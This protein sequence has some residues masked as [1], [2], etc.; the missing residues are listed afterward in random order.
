MNPS[1]TA[2]GSGDPDPTIEVEEPKAPA[3]DPD[4][5]SIVALFFLTNTIL[6][7]PCKR[8]YI[9]VTIRDLQ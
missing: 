4:Q 1:S 2:A 6:G 5:I 9:R 3:E 8:V 7:V